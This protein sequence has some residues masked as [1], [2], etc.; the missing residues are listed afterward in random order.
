MCKLFWPL[1]NI[2]RLPI[3]LLSQ[4]RFLRPSWKLSKHAPIFGQVLVKQLDP[5][6]R[7]QGAASALPAAAG[8]GA[9]VAIKTEL[10]GELP[11]HL[12]FC[13]SGSVGASDTVVA[14]VTD[15]SLRKLPRC[16]QFEGPTISIAASR[17]LCCK[18]QQRKSPSQA[19]MLKQ[20]DKKVKDARRKLR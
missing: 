8:Y 13:D 9:D 16:I 3:V 20:S 17:S 14:Q 11:A 5:R 18:H 19:A 4:Q 12:A 1:L 10:T 2:S 15:P 6:W 7:V